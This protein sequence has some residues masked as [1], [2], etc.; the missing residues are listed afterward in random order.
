[1]ERELRLVEQA[2]ATNGARQARTYATLAV[3]NDSSG[4]SRVERGFVN[5]RL[6]MNRL[7]RERYALALANERAASNGPPR[8][9]VPPR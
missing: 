7:A 6:E 1:M 9:G 5:R 2:H 8:H 4:F 3:A